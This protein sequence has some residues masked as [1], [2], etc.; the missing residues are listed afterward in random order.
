MRFSHASYSQYIK[1]LSSLLKGETLY[2]PVLVNYE[3]L[4]FP[5]EKDNYKAL[6]ISLNHKEPLVYLIEHSRFLSSFENPFFLRFKKRIQKSLVREIKLDEKDNIVEIVFETDGEIE[7]II[8]HVFVELI[9][10]KPNMILLDE[11]DQIVEAYYKDKNRSLIKGEKYIKPSQLESLNDGVSISK[12]I[13]DNHFSNELV[14]RREEK[15]RDFYRY[16]NGKIRLANRKI[17]AIEEDVKKA[18]ENL[19][20]SDLADNILCLG[21]DLKSHKEKVEVNGMVISLNSSKTVLE[22]VQHFY[23]RASKA[24]ETIVRSE[25]NIATAKDEIASYEELLE[26][27]KT[28]DEKGADKLI[29]EIGM[30]KKKKE[31]K[32]TPFNRPYKVNFNGTIIYFGRNASQNDYLSF[33]MKLDREFTWM[34]IKDKSGAHLVIANKNPTEKELLLASEL[35]LLCSRANAGEVVYTKKKNVRRGHTLGEAILKN[36][37][38]IKINSVSKETKDIFAKAE[39]LK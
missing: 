24:K 6:V 15:Y 32:E 28:L 30:I 3:T 16:V 35:S 26:R 13:I 1:E 27:F 18:N 12:E 8:S 36:H 17:K 9:T 10:C 37:S 33:V 39:R 31:V 20:Y 34:H 5:L 23:K 25:A 2:S 38:V 14:I 19:A 4:I 21:L 29:A 22:N 11:N 7:P